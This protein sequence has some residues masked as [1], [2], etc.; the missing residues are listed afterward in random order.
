MGWLSVVIKDNIKQVSW[1][2]G[3]RDGRGVD[4]SRVEWRGVEE[5]REGGM[6]G[7]M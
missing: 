1:R 5:E 7:G 3:E 2:E 6:E 4:G